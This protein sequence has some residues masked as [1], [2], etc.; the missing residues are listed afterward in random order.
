LSLLQT[1]TGRSR[2]R[3]DHTYEQF[4]LFVAVTCGVSDR[5]LDALL[6][7]ASQWCILSAWVASSL[8]FDLE[9]ASPEARL[10]TRFGELR[11]RLERIPVYF[12]AEEG[13]SVEV[14]ATWFLSEG[15]IG[16]PVI[17]WKGCLERVRFALDPGEEQFYFAEL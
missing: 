16:P 2:Y 17:G 1:F 15:C 13:E 3:P 8:G 5:P 14:E 12:V 7:T 4:L 9:A 11:G 10:S 6:D